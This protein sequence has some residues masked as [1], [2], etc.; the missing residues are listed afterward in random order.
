MSDP[1][2]AP[3]NSGIDPD[4]ISFIQASLAEASNRRAASVPLQTEISRGV[5]V[6]TV[7][8][9]S[10]TTL[11]QSQLNS[12]IEVFGGGGGGASGTFLASLVTN[13][14]GQ[15]TNIKVTAGSYHILNTNTD[16]P[17]TEADGKYVYAIIEHSNAGI[18]KSFK[19]EIS[20]SSKDPTNLDGTG[21]FV[22]FSNILLAEGMV[23]EGKPVMVQRRAGNFS[24][25][26][27]LVE[28][29]LCLW[30]YSS[31]GTSA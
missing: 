20:Q 29:R 9:P 16:V 3:L 6:N 28:G 8:I 30:V 14:D 10:T 31:G 15:V 23:V 22:K 21:K 2:N 5:Q 17:A 4:Q 13:E 27:Q 24:I 18:F 19:I 25:V 1:F 11:P 26:H 12:S 7:I